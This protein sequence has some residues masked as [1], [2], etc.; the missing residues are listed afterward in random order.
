MAAEKA[1]FWRRIAASKVDPER[2]RPEMKWILLSKK[3]YHAVLGHP[4]LPKLGA[5]IVQVRQPERR[6]S[7]TTSPSHRWP[8]GSQCDGVDAPARVA[9]RARR[10]AAL[11]PEGGDHCRGVEAGVV[12]VA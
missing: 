7:A 11:R 6:V 3:L 9:Y 12:A 1:G 10:D 4:G 5:S 2:G 8:Y